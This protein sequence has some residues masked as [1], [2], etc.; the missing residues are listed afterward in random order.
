MWP[1]RSKD[2]IPSFD[3]TNTIGRGSSVRGDVAGPGG[4][5]IDG[6]VEGAIDGDGPVVIGEGG[7]VD[8]AVRGCDV[9]VL[10]SVRGDVTASAHLEIGPKGKVLG[11]IS[12][13]SF[14]LHEGGVFRGTSRMADEGGVPILLERNEYA[15]ALV[16][17]RGRTL[18]PPMGTGAVPPP[19]S[20]ADLAA[21]TPGASTSDV[22]TT[23]RVATLDLEDMEAESHERIAVLEDAEK[24]RAVG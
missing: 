11:D 23:T 7:V 17:H 22:V 14:R 2:A 13:K 20:L 18:P 4:F 15:A 21:M 6:R 12:V 24:R 10:G 1:F 16:A 8:G 9:I 19:P 3:V 5:R